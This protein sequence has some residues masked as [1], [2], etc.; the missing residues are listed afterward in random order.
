ML[1]V[2]IADLQLNQS[3]LF[4]KYPSLAL[5]RFSRNVKGLMA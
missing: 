3:G 2:G 4:W 5:L 1:R